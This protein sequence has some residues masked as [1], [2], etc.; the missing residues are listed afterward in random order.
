MKTNTINL[1]SKELEEGNSRKHCDFRTS[2][3]IFVMESFLLKLTE[4]LIFFLKSEPEADL[5]EKIVFQFTSSSVHWLLFTEISRNTIHLSSIWP[6][7]D[8]LKKN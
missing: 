2:Y 3:G 1:I 5:F 7:A 4:R 6:V 8:L